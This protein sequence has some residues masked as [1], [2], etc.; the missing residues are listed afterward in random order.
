MEL[1]RRAFVAVCI[2]QALAPS[3]AAAKASAGLKAAAHSAVRQS[4][5]Q[6]VDLIAQSLFALENSA[7]LPRNVNKTQEVKVLKVLEGREQSLEKRLQDI[8]DNDRK[9]RALRSKNKLQNLTAHMKPADRAMMEKMDDWDQRMNRKTRLG[10]MDVISKLKNTIHL[11]KKGALRGNA[12]AQA[13]LNKVLEKM[14]AM[15][16]QGTSTFLH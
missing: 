11:I 8:A 15:A 7:S 16:G 6:R 4:A 14:G 9:E 3:A 2:L 13:S 12:D 5:G 1:V 10:A